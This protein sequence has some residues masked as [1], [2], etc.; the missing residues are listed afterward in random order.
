MGATQKRRLGSLAKVI[1]SG[2]VKRQPCRCGRPFYQA[3]TNGAPEGAPN[4][5]VYV[6]A[7]GD[8]SGNILADTGVVV[9]GQLSRDAHGIAAFFRYVH[10]EIP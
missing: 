9:A 5:S 1:G 7:N 4:D 8:I 10:V 2:F 3:K 6:S